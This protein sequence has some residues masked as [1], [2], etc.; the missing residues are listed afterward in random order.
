MT[1]PLP[2]N[3]PPLATQTDH[4]PSLLSEDGAELLCEALKGPRRRDLSG[5]I[6]LPAADMIRFVIGPDQSV[7]A[8]LKG[9][10]P[11]RGLWVKADRPSLELV[12]SK[13]L[14]SK[15][16]K[17]KVQIPQGFAD[18][19]HQRLRLRVLDLLGLARR[20]GLIVSGF[21]K[22][23]ALIRSN[24]PHWLIEASDGAQDG[25]TKLL[26]LAFAHQSAPKICASFNNQELSLALGLENAI[27]VALLGG[28]R[29]ER[30]SFEMKRLSGFEPLMP[31]TWSSSD[32]VRGMAEKIR[33]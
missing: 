32:L 9:D 17:R 6:S 10:L 19:V 21:E 26:N 25:R 20:E 7:V 31:L 27:H 2:N 29:S 23:A 5:A 11:G 8:D 30:W 22:V 18:Q 14:F 24:K 15:A 33:S 16:A 28:R 12:I 3:E 13:N 4:T 1:S